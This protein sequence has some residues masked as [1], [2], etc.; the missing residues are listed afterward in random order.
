MILAEAIRPGISRIGTIT[1]SVSSS[2]SDT[3]RSTW[4]T[5]SARNEKADIALDRGV[6]MHLAELDDCVG[7][8]AGLLD[9]LAPRGVHRRL[10]LGIDHSARNLDRE[11]R[12]AVTPLANHHD[13]AVFRERN[14][15]HPVGRV[16]DEE[17][18]FAAARVR[19]VPA[20]EIEDRRAVGDVAA[21]RLPLARLHLTIARIRLRRR[22]RRATRSAAAERS[23]TSRG[24]RRAFV[25]R[26]RR[27]D[28]T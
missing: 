6:G 23:R 12:D 22:G 2:P 13:V 3:T 4:R 1:T 17:V 28:G 16:E 10:V 14:D 18:A 25:D 15:I 24:W 20:M 7:I 21:E 26:G 19:R 11:F 8:E 27:R 5:F 9:H